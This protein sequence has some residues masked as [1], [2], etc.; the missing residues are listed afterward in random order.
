[1]AQH[2]TDYGLVYDDEGK[3]CVTK[4]TDIIPFSGVTSYA[5]E[6]G[7][8]NYVLFPVSFSTSPAGVSIEYLDDYTAKVTVTDATQ[9]T[10]TT[11][12]LF[13]GGRTVDA[14]TTVT[15][16]EYVE[17]TNTSNILPRIYGFGVM[18]DHEGKRYYKTITYS[19]SWQFR[20][21]VRILT[22]AVNGDYI[23]VSYPQIEIKPFAS[24][25]VIGTRPNGR[26]VVPLEKLGF[27]PATDDWVVQYWKYPVATRTNDLTDYNLCSIGK[28]TSDKSQGYIWWGKERGSNVFRIVIVYNDS[29]WGSAS[30]PSFD[31]AWYFRNWH[32]EVFLKHGSEMQYWID[33]TLQ[34]QLALAKPLLNNFVVGLTLGGYAHVPANNSYIANECY[35]FYTD[36]WTPEYIQEIYQQR[37]GFFVPPKA[38][39]V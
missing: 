29:T 11:D 18:T 36:Q 10:E 9:I 32:H 21:G 30:S 19:S 22:T 25:F 14:N 8:T 27:N 23:I 35:G 37:N 20:V 12:I 38:V 5:V 13:N 4:R 28:Y 24:S 7:T 3:I 34:S 6:T 26:L 17:S 39:I 33:G 1:M 31:P 2:N 15:V 16:S